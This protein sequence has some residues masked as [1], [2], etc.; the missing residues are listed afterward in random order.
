[1]TINTELCRSCHPEREGRPAWSMFPLMDYN[2]TTNSG[3]VCGSSTVWLR[4]SELQLPPTGIAPFI[5]LFCEL[6]WFSPTSK[7][8]TMLAVDSRVARRYLCMRWWRFGEAGHGSVDSMTRLRCN[9]STFPGQTA[10]RR[11]ADRSSRRPSTSP[12][13]PRK[14]RE[15]R[16]YEGAVDTPFSRV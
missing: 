8:P 15:P 14:C 5:T 2:I 7:R 1:M 16:D 11:S 12:S 3:K 6:T 9:R 10:R 4:I 13:L